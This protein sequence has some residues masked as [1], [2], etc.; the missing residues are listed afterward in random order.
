MATSFPTISHYVTTT[1]PD[2]TSSF[3]DSPNPP[4]SFFPNHAFRVDYI[5]SSQP[6]ATGPPF[7]ENEDLKNHLEVAAH[8]PYIMFPTA[9]G[10]AAAV[11][12]V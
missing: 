12:N 3:H 9:G 11:L 1:N 6:S 8:P 2:G 7:A 5:Y 4:P 10:S